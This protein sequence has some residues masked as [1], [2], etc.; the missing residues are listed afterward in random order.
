MRGAL[1]TTPFLP[2]L[3]VGCWGLGR[4]MSNESS[5]HNA[6]AKRFQIDKLGCLSVQELNI[7]VNLTPLLC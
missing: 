2:A 3:A 4:L 5:K 6:L 7:Y 1:F